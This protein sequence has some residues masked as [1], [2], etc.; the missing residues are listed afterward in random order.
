M[1]ALLAVLPGAA[2]AATV[3]PR[4]IVLG[5]AIA[6][7]GRPGEVKRV[8]E[9]MGRR[10]GAVMWFQSF[11]EPLFYPGQIRAVDRIG[12]IPIITWTAVDARGPIPLA[13][14]AQ[15]WWDR[16]LERAAAAAAAYGRPLWIRFGHEMNL[17]LARTGRPRDPPA[18]FVRA[19]RHVVEVFRA[20]GATN[21]RW[22]WS[23]NV[24]CEG[25][26]PF[27]AFYPGDAWVDRVALDGYNIGT[28]APWSRWQTVAEIFGP[29]Y[30][31]LTRLTGKP[32]MI[33][34]TASTEVG[35]SKGR[36]IR[37]GLLEDVPRRL[38]RVGAVIWFDRPKEQPWQVDSS[39]GALA[40][41]RA[42]A[43]SAL[44]AGRWRTGARAEAPRDRPGLLPR[45]LPLLLGAAVLLLVVRSARR[46]L[47]YRRRPFGA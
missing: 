16:Y 43:A 46:A 6:D 40:A 36:W 24:D 15:G 44:Y 3:G 42:V 27:A 7:P 12:A 10:P 19:W 25:R 34:E 26:C 45:A 35:G 33:A 29:S 32:I 18:T 17:L 31:A 13:E 11:A 23:P 22:V 37:S 47:A 20:A 39:P 30:D 14:V 5:V 41:F 2:R 9:R 4:P 28:I 38:P 1:L 21:V 8:E